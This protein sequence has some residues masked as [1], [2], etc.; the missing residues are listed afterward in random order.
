[1]GC[2]EPMAR[3]G[4]F[5]GWPRSLGVLARGSAQWGRLCCGQTQVQVQAWL[6]LEDG[7]DPDRWVPAVSERKNGRG[8]ERAG[9]AGWVA[10]GGELV[11]GLGRMMEGEEKREG[12]LGWARG[13]NRKRER[14][15]GP[16]QKERKREKKKCIQMHLNLHLKLNSNGRQA[17]QLCNSA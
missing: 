17:M 2:A 4:S 5:I 8:K 3:D 10:G 1:V 16:G 13:G 15:D 7:D 6:V 9:R 12:Q 14:E 11:A